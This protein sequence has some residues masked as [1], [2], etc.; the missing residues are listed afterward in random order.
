[1]GMHPSIKKRSIMVSSM[2]GNAA[3]DIVDGNVASKAGDVDD[4]GGMTCGAEV[5]RGGVEYIGGMK[6]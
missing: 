2:G 5:F 4:N 6:V 3:V 1:M